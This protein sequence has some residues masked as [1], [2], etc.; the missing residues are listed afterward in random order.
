[1]EQGIITSKSVKEDSV[2]RR[3]GSLTVFLLV[4]LEGPLNVHLVGTIGG[5]IGS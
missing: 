2:T 5:V 1:M 3:G 4:V